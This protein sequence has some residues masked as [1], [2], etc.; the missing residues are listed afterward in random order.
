MSIGGAVTGGTDMSILFVHPSATLAQDVTNFSWDDTNK[1]L[2]IGSSGTQAVVYLNTLPALYQ[3]PAVSGANWFEGN[4][5]NTTLTGYLNFGTGDGSLVSLTSGYQNTAVGSNSGHTFTSGSNNIAIGSKSLE[6]SAADNFNTAIGYGAVDYLGYLGA[7]GGNNQ[8]NIGIGYAAMGNLQSGSG[9]IGLGYTCLLNLVTNCSNNVAIGSIAGNLLGNG[10]STS[11]CTMIGYNCGANITVGDNN[12]WLGGYRG[13]SSCN[14]TICI[15]IGDGNNFLD[16]NLMSG[17]VWSM[18]A[19]YGV[20]PSGLHIY[21][22]QSPAATTTNYERAILDWNPTANIFRVGTQAGGTGVVRLVA[23]DG[24]QKAGAPAAG[25]LPSG[26]CAL[27]NDTSGGNTWLVY[28][29]AGTIRKVQL[30]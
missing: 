7:G 26:T 16:W 20:Y 9:N 15:S 1:Y 27:I 22:L 12:V 25:D 13:P 4:A 11:N 28:N 30:T 19:W 21:N 17:Q 24:F 23:I 2:K 29:A 14:R 3:I 5:G 8:G 18:N 10:G 6:Y